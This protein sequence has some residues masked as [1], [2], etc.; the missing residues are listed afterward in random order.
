MCLPTR[1]IL[2]TWSCWRRSVSAPVRGTWSLPRV[3]ES[4]GPLSE[5]LLE[6][7]DA[8]ELLGRRMRR[9]G[10]LSAPFFL[11]KRAIRS[12]AST[13]RR[14]RQRRH[15]D[16]GSP[17]GRGLRHHKHHIRSQALELEFA[18]APGDAMHAG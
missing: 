11:T 14:D 5:R 2:R 13:E 16:R 7:D 12:G 17:G 6:S 4:R 15:R 8:L 1:W 10:R 3:S 18:V 9:A